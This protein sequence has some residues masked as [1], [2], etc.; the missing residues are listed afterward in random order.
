VRRS[1]PKDKESAMLTALLL[2]AYL[3][4]GLAYAMG[5]RRGGDIITERPYNNR[6]SDA[7]GARQDHLG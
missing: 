4:V 3:V 1:D 2:T 7:T 6:Y 5:T